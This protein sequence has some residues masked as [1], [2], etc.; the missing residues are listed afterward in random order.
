VNNSKYHIGMLVLILI[1]LTAICPLAFAQVTNASL[2]GLV[3]DASGAAVTGV[4]I[5]V[6]NT[7]TSFVQRTVSNE[8]GIYLV[9]PLNPGPYTLTAEKKGFRKLVQTGI[10]LTVDQAATL[11][12]I[13]QVGDT[14]E[15]VTVTADAELIN[16]TTAEV[17]TTVGEEAVSELPLGGRQTSALVF[18]SAG[19]VNVLQTAGGKTQG[20]TTMPDATGASAGGG[21]QGSTYYMLDGAP[22]MDTYMSLAA[23]F[24]DPDATQEFR[25][26]TNNYDAHYGF[27]PGAIVTIQ[28]KSGTNKFHGGAYD[29]IRNQLANAS[30]YFGHNVDALHRNLFGGSFGGPVL[31]NKLF[32]FGN[33]E[34]T[35]EGSQGFNNFAN[36][37]T[38]KML[39]GDFTE[40]LSS[41]GVMQV[42]N[43]PDNL[44]VGNKTTH[45]SPGAVAMATNALP[46]GTAGA[47]TNPG[48]TEYP[49]SPGKDTYKQGTTRI[50][51]NISDKQRIFQRSFIDYYTQNGSSIKGNWIAV[52]PTHLGE[53][54]NE[55]LGHTWTIND[56]TVNV[57]NVY[58]AQMDFLSEQEALDKSG[59]PVCL[60][61][62]IAVT[63]PT[64][65]CY[66]MGSGANGGSNGFWSNWTEPT[67]ERRYTYGLSDALTKTI[68]SHTL[69]AGGEFMHLFAQENTDYPATVNAQFNGSW[70]GFGIA[71]FLTGNVDSF[72][73]G[74]GEISSLKGWMMGVYAQD[75]YRI[76]PNLTVTLG[77]R[78]DPNTPPTVTGGRGSQW[79]PGVQ[80]TMF[81]NAPLGMIFPGDAGLDAR[82]MPGSYNNWNPRVGIAYQP[83]ALPKT[84]FRAGF[85]IFTGPLQYSAYNH[86][87]DIAPFSPTFNFNSHVDT[88][89]PA[90]DL[91]IPFDAPW[92]ADYLYAPGAPK[93]YPSGNQFAAGNFASLHYTPPKNSPIVTPVSLGA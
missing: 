45:L 93:L 90:N 50:D 87:S 11:N 16:T 20:E 74:G 17:G 64:G 28:T 88:G 49:G 63:E 42:I 22:N 31:K 53:V 69:S 33:F 1:C 4:Q 71:D 82:L 19:V 23:S 58:Y 21:R 68:K 83:K 14:K 44:F 10:T 61:K 66:M 13:L 51:Y 76:K 15:T 35:H 59:A 46:V 78:W 43:G 41:P 25:V 48:Y 12:L 3:T 73:Q 72:T 79:R 38:A 62:Y 75:Q 89:T 84:S 7:N 92:T 80:S 18:L 67:S 26:V 2:T 40:V 30:N 29:F 32:F 47:S 6:Q 37:P 34:H 57:V 70:T 81:P 60:S 52:T 24:P 9:A 39:T 85:G 91:Q 77:L 65:H 86:T 55:A 5:S 54:Y 36:F 56:T 8:A 27:A